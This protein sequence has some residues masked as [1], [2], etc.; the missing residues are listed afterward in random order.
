M[1]VPKG[2]RENLEWR[3]K[4]LA[5]CKEDLDLRA[6]VRELYERDPIFAFNGFFWTYDPRKRPF[7]HQPFLTYGYEDELILELKESVESGKD[8]V[9]DKSRDMGITWV[10]LELFEWFWTKSTGGF[11]F[12]V[13]SRI[14]DYVDKKGDPRTHFERLRYNLYRLPKWLRPRGFDRGKH[15]NF[16][17]LVNP[18]TG[19]A[20]TGESN[21][22][23][24]STQGRYAAVFFDEFAKWEVTDEKAW[25][26]AGDA[27]PCRIAGSTPFGAGGQFYRLVMGAEGGAKRLRYHWSLHP[28][29]SVGLSCLWP[30]PN[31]DDR[32]RMG[33]D[34]KPVEKLV[35]PWYMRETT[36]RRQTEI[37]QE[38]DIDYIG[39]GN[40]VFD[41][42]AMDS[43]RFYVGV[44]DEPKGWVKLDLEGLKWTESGKP[45]DSEG[46][47]VVYERRD[48]KRRYV[49]GVDVVEG[50]EDGDFAFVTVLDRMSKCVAG[51]YWSRVDEVTL[52]RVARVIADYYSSAPNAVDSP[53]VGVETNGPGLATFDLCILL[54]M[55]NLF[56]MVRYDVVSGG[57]T[58]KKGWRTDQAS[59]NELIS[60]VREYLIN[61]TGALNSSRLVGELMTFVRSKTGKPGAKSGCHDD[62]VMSF[63]IALQVD[64]MVPVEVEPVKQLRQE[65][66]MDV[67]LR[68]AEVSKEP[69]LTLEQRCF[70]HAMSKKHGFDR[71]ENLWEQ[72]DQ[73]TIEGW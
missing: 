56:M 41:G 65:E 16:M 57:N 19:S 31:D 4:L 6:V 24:F 43:L 21:N 64:Q 59:K 73:D 29:K 69:E 51:V 14:A 12:L 54:G 27:T 17:K 9:I 48:P 18:E 30:T 63:G 70:A 36:R 5:R 11:D 25:M 20:I 2:Y 38:L 7:H 8:T 44:K 13:G 22:A 33:E 62:G 52:A 1:E 42:K 49:L 53:W 3:G 23:N 34:F 28:E 72:I 39:A 58:L 61:R 10:V 66:M 71:E 35:S 15:D 67:L 45:F 37:A 55:T 68:K 46:F 47:L 60:G 50:T 40:P 32:G 26:S